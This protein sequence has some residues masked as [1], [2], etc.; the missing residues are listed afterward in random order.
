MVHRSVGVCFLS[1]EPLKVGT[2]LLNSLDHPTDHRIEQIHVLLNPELRCVMLSK[3]SFDS[4]QSY[5]IPLVH[6]P[7]CV[8][9]RVFEEIGRVHPTHKP[10]KV[11]STIVIESS[12]GRFLLCRRDEDSCIFPKAWVI[13]G[14]H[15]EH[16]EDLEQACMRELSEETGINIKQVGGSWIYKGRQAAVKALMLF[17]SNYYD[18]EQFHLPK[19]QH[20]IVTFYAALPFPACDIDLRLDPN[21]I[22]MAVWITV[23]DLYAIRGGL[24]GELDAISSDPDRKV[25]NFFQLAGFAPNG[26]GEGMGRAA[27]MA[28]DEVLRLRS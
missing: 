12:D 5:C 25:V 27:S 9:R 13:P 21:E 10:I 24:V 17:E 20:L 28:L 7:I 15:V 14:G 11:A 3:H 1:D 18:L 2:C 19:A 26:L 6:S 16:G 8:A 4:P 22:D 23:E